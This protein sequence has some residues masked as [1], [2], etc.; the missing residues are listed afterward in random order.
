MKRIFYSCSID[1]AKAERVVESNSA[2]EILDSYLAKQKEKYESDVE[3][4]ADSMFGFS[5]N[6]SDF[7]EISIDSKTE[8]R[9]KLECKFKKKLW[10]FSWNSLY[11]KEYHVN[12][13]DALKELITKFFENEVG[14]YKEQF[15]SLPF[16][17]SYLQRF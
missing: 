16:K 17:V 6:R 9:I 14:I 2:L 15:D 8:Y 7:I 13:I 11:Q 10:F 3:A 1:G 5:I 12:V 4:I